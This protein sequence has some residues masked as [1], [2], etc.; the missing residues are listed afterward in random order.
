M[1]PSLTPEDQ[2]LTRRVLSMQ[3]SQTMRITALAN[4]MKAEGKDIVSLSAGEP[5]F[6][7]PENVN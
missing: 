6:P 4:K 2:F 1:S 7:T 5:D 3:E